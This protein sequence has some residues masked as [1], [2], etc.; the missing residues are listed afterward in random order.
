MQLVRSSHVSSVDIFYLVQIALRLS[1]GL[2]K[3]TKRFRQRLLKKRL[4]SLITS[5]PVQMES[6]QNG[7]LDILSL[8]GRQIS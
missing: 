1:G 3:T 4:L 2:M 8:V 6:L 7:K 5:S